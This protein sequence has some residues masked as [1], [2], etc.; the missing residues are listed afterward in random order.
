MKHLVVTFDFP[1]NAAGVGSFMAEIARRLDPAET[2]VLTL[3]QPQ[4]ADAERPYRVIRRDMTSSNRLLRQVF[5]LRLVPEAAWVV[6][7]AYRTYRHL[8]QAVRENRP[9]VIHCGH[10][11]PVGLAGAMLDA[12]DPA[13]L[14]L[15]AHGSELGP[16]QRFL[17][18]QRLLRRIFSRVDLVCATSSTT[19]GV[20]KDMGVEGG[21]IVHTPPPIDLERFSPGDGDP[22]LAARYRLQG[23][24]VVL[25]VGRLLPWRGFRTLVRAM[26]MVVRRHPDATLVIVGG[27]SDAGRLADRVSAYRLEDAVRLVGVQPH[28]T[29]PAWYRLAEMV[30]LP[31]TASM[32]GEYEGLGLSLIEGGACGRA[33]VAGRGSGPAEAVVEDETGLLCDGA[34]AEDIARAIN[35]LLDDDALRHRMGQAARRHIE[36]MLDGG[37]PLEEL[38]RRLEE[39]GGGGR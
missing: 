33:A 23:R 32:Y 18:G 10:L 4:A 38:R 22:D 20:L 37:N 24:R 11:L 14:V 6:I 21:R 34:D 16:P 31:G 19:V 27:G 39:I 28:E 26:P 12:D 8:R 13:R 5:R 29:L 35:A 3:P 17:F 25:A 2:T 1:P 7:E 36:R 30:V 9:D 15:Y